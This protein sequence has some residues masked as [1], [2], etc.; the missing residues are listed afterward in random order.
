[1][2]GDQTQYC[3]VPPALSGERVLQKG[4]VCTHGHAR[5]ARLPKRTNA[6]NGRLHR[7]DE[8]LQDDS[9]YDGISGVHGGRKNNYG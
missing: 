9:I 8:N 7:A 2:H 6:K 4:R 1:M 5:P 3:V